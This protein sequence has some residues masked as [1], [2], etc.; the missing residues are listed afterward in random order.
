MRPSAGHVCSRS[1]AGPIRPATALL[2]A[3]IVVAVP[4]SAQQAA[5]D[6]ERWDL[7]WQHRYRE[8][9]RGSQPRDTYLR[10]LT[11]MRLGLIHSEI[12]RV[13][14]PI[15]RDYLHVLHALSS[16]TDSHATS[17][18]YTPYYLALSLREH[19]ELER[20]VEL[21]EAFLTEPTSSFPDANGYAA[22]ALGSSLYA[23]GRHGEA[24]KWFQDAM[25]VAEENAHVAAY[26]ALEWTRMG[27]RPG[28]A[29]DLMARVMRQ[30]S[31]WAEA[32]PYSAIRRAR[33]L[34]LH[35][36]HADA[37]RAIDAVQGPKWRPAP[38]VEDASLPPRRIE[39]FD[40]RMFR[41][42]AEVYMLAALD[43]FS[44][45]SDD[46]L[47]HEVSK[48]DVSFAESLLLHRL[49]RYSDAAAH[50]EQTRRDDAWPE[51]MRH[52]A[53]VLLGACYSAQGDADTAMRLWAEVQAEQTN[54]AVDLAYAYATAKASPQQAAVLVAR[55]MDRLF[56]LTGGRHITQEYP[57]EYPPAR[58]FGPREVYRRASEAALRLHAL[59]GADIDVREM[60]L[61]PEQELIDYA[62]ILSL[63]GRNLRYPYAIGDVPYGNDPLMLVDM[64]YMSYERGFDHWG[65]ATETYS[66]MQES[67]REVY[68]L[69]TMIQLIYA[70]QLGLHEDLRG[71]TRE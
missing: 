44:R 4:A 7:F 14:A 40:P 54:V 8:I 6:E 47:T 11:Y 17:S 1:A 60:G 10:A 45:L 50:I 28:A 49:A 36:R 70:T 5:G 20:A 61:R 42:V 62:R 52:H 29:G 66:V 56:A 34:S 15:S 22:C 32:R 48:Y 51:H 31:D 43:V 63:R 69:H 33:A 12:D 46:D 27:I 58:A 35:G 21:L 71:R 2:L 24:D 16:R 3:A 26:L 59:A 23:L 38:E 13:M 57:T 68:P 64:G 41:D 19:G 37:L 67:M 53:E 55:A 65:E 18:E 30:G 9:E 39:F 25:A